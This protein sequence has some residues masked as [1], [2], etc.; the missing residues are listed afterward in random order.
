MSLLASDVGGNVNSFPPVNLSAS[1]SV[2]S[3]SGQ[4]SGNGTYVTSSSSG[5][6]YS[7]FSGSGYWV[8][9]GGQYS[10]GSGAYGGS[11]VTT[12]VASTSYS[13]EWLQIQLPYAIIPS[14]YS[15][16]SSVFGG[17]TPS[18]FVLLGSSDRAT[19]YTVDS[20]TSGALANLL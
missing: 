3:L 5:N 1:L 17:K 11:F 18:T 19:W 8:S 13:G 15:L 12:D 2:T 9:A 14:A 7:A 6:A 16:T 20:R 10:T 4:A